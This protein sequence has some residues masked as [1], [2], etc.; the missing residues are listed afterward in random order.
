MSL[1]LALFLVV[2]G[3]VHIGYVCSQ[4]WPFEA[5][6]PW[7]VTAFGAAPDTVDNIGIALVLVTF[8][9]FLLAAPTAVGILPSRLWAPLIAVG[10][11]A[12]AIVLVMFITPGTI[13]GLAIDAVLL[14]AVLARKWRPT[15]LIGRR[16]QSNRPVTS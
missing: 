15:P 2:H 9:A 1:L 16:A 13:P 10:S 8:F 11:V 6:D 7:L 3:G 5:T 12:S 14:S 4:S